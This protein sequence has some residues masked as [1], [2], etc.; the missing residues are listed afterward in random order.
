MSITVDHE[1]ISVQAGSLKEVAVRVDEVAS[2]IP[3]AVDGGLGTAAI[4]GILSRFVASGGELVAGLAGA[5][6][7]LG[8]CATRYAEQD[9]V[10]ADEINAA[11]WAE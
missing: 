2:S 1:E 5:G 9:V 11:A 3:V 4:L 8:E 7:V 10:A 6:A